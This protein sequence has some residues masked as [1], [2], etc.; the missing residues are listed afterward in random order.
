MDF[1][2]LLLVVPLVWFVLYQAKEATNQTTPKGEPKTGTF[3]MFV[4]VISVLLAGAFIIT[5]FGS[6]R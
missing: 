4:I 5:G 2:L 3:I 6:P 1:G